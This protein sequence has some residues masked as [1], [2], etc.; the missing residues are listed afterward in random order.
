MSIFRDVFDDRGDRQR[1][2]SG[3]GYGYPEWLPRT[4][5]AHAAML[6]WDGYLS[7]IGRS[8]RRRFSPPLPCE[9]VVQCLEWRRGQSVRP[10]RASSRPFETP[11]IHRD[12]RYFA[13]KQRASGPSRACWESRAGENR[14]SSR[15]FMP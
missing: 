4:P 8:M 9:A 14:G 1:I 6:L 2:H 7:V 13:G 12:G 11:L 5:R 3:H 15:E 10:S